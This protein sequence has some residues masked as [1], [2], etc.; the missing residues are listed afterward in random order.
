MAFDKQYPNR[1][2]WR[3]PY[4]KRGRYAKSCRP[5]GG[6]PYCRESR[7]HATRR[8]MMKAADTATD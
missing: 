2:D 1:K 7:L 5:N 3:R 8:R 4:R 6:C